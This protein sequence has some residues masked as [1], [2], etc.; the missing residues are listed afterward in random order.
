MEKFYEIFNHDI[1]TERLEM[2][3]LKPTI[4][5]AQM[6]WDVLN[7]ENPAD[8]QYMWYSAT[9]KSHLPESV[10]ETLKIMQR[11]AGYK[12]GIVWYIFHNGKFVGYQRFHYIDRC[13]TIQ[14][15]S[16]WFI[17]S[18]RGQGFNQEVHNLIDKLGFE[19][20]GVNRICRQAMEGNVCSV[21]SIKKAGYQLDGVE[22]AANKM[23]DG[24]Y[25]NH[26]LFSK[27]KSEYKGK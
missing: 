6:I 16:V 9:H 8:Y 4:A 15:S 17:K 20:L 5:N 10:D 11:D 12:D 2:R 26:L 23:P 1:K 21:N 25:M 19:E 22:R 18:A 24:T 7:R 27:L 14:C 3:V 13:D